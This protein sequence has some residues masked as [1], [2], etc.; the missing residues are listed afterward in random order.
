[1]TK[2]HVWCH[3]FDK[4][5]NDPLKTT[6]HGFLLSILEQVGTTQE[7]LNHK[8]F[9]EIYQ[10]KKAKNILVTQLEISE[11]ESLLSK[12]FQN[13]KIGYL[14]IDAM[15]ECAQPDLMVK[16]FAKIPTNIQILATSR[17]Q[18]DAQI[19]VRSMIQLEGRAS[20][21]IDINKYVDDEVQNL[22][23]E[24]DLQVRVSDNL[25]HGANGQ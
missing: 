19:H 17:H 1:M 9:I 14:V 8:A 16:W 25:K 22:D 5:G 23:I 4:S 12:L 11:P 18:N 6:Y 10:Q 2:D 3:Y 7:G 21:D 24:E 20:V 13:G 15:D